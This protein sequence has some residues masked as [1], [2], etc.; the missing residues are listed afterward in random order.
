MSRLHESRQ[1]KL[2]AAQRAWIQFR[3]KNA[4]F[5]ASDFEGGSMSPLISIYWLSLMT[6][7]RLSEL[8]EILQETPVE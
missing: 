1:E 6:E 5:M 8:R 4:E 3:D 2:K 7:H